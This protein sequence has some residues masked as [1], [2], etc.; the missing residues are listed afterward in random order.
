VEKAGYKVSDIPNTWDA[1]ID[2]FLPM[3]AKLRAKGM[4]PPPGRQ[5]QPCATLVRRRRRIGEL[6]NFAPLTARDAA[7]PDLVDALASAARLRARARPAIAARSITAG[8]GKITFSARSAKISPETIGCPRSVPQAA[9]AAASIMNGRSAT[10]AA[11]RP[12]AV[13]R[14]R[15]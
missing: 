13:A 7:A 11:R 15:A 12:N 1:Y 3:Q 2:F 6:F 8:A 4:Q 10:L 14:M 5:T 9:C